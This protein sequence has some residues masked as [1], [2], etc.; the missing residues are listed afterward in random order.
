VAKRTFNSRPVVTPELSTAAGV[1]A[2]ELTACV[3]AILASTDRF[4]KATAACPETATVGGI[5]RGVREGW[6]HLSFF[7]DEAARVARLVEPEPDV[8][9]TE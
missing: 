4:Q 8:S 1:L 7:R 6:D 9:P 3:D 5:M 2:A